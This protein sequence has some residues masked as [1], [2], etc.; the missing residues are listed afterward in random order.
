[1]WRHCPGN[2][3]PADSPSRGT[4]ATE[5]YDLL[6]ER[7]NGSNF[8]RQSI[9][10]VD[11]SVVD[12]SI[13]ED[14]KNVNVAKSVC[15]KDLKSLIGIR[16]YSTANRLF[17]VMSC[18]LRFISN[19]KL[20]VQRKETKNIYLTAEEIEITE[21]TWIKSVQKEFFKDKSNL[22]QFQI[23][24]GVYL[25][26]DNIYKC[27]GRLVN[28]SLPEYSKTPIF[29]RKESYLSNLIILKSHQ[30]LKHNG[31]KDTINHERSIY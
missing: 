3:N 5:F 21:Y 18:I 8:L 17:R 31:I 24:H 14:N 23:K 22:N 11:I 25:D 16:K 20:S 10:T 26:T 7:N 9:N 6:R 15:S 1:M 27:N 2:V 13:S 19:L 4:T 28:S 12:S 29:L 30:N